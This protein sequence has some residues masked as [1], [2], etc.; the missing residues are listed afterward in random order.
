MTAPLRI[1]SLTPAPAQVCPSGQS[2]SNW[3]HCW[4]EP[5]R[6]CHSRLVLHVLGYIRRADSH[7][8]CG[9]CWIM[10]LLW[11]QLV[12]SPSPLLP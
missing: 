12:A 3:L 8:S 1:G 11:M 7:R 4:A 2:A 5:V 10:G 6:V 9:F